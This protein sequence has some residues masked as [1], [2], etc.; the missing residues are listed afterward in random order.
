MRFKKFV[1]SFCYS[2]YQ[3]PRK[4]ICFF[5]FKVLFDSSYFIYLLFFLLIFLLFRG[6]YLSCILYHEDRVLV[7]NEDFLPVIEVDE[8]YPSCIYNDFHWLM[9][10]SFTTSDVAL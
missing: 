6:V 5:F 7:T 8:T 2:R 10:V 3:V 9:K 1:G 4:L